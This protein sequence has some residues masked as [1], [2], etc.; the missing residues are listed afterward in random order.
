MK[1]S[2]VSKITLYDT[3]EINAIERGYLCRK[4]GYLKRTRF[5]ALWLNLFGFSKCLAIY[6]SS[7]LYLLA[8]F[9]TLQ[10]GESL[11]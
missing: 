6:F 4:I 3:D 2:N 1:V 10:A 5:C 11:L 8:L 7:W 9:V